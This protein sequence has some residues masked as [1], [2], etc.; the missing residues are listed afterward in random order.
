M[1]CVAPYCVPGGVRVVSV[2]VHVC[3]TIRLAK[4][5]HPKYVQHLAGHAI[6]QLILDHYSHWKEA[7]HGRSTADGMDEAL[8]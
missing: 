2:Q 3:F 4:G 6:I 5:R 8:G 7:F 1:P